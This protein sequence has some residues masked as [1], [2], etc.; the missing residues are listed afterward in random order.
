MTIHIYKRCST[1]Q[2]A[3]SEL[4]IQAQSD[5]CLEYAKQY[6]G[7]DIREYADCGYS[8]SLD[9]LKRPQLNMLM[10][11]L[12]KGDILLAYDSSRIA[13]DTLIW[14]NIEMTC[15]RIGAKIVL[16]TGCN[17]ESLETELIRR[18][19]AQVNEYSLNKMKERTVVALA[20]KKKQGYKLGNA[21]YGYRHS[22]DRKSYIVHEEEQKVISLVY[23]MRNN[24]TSW[25]N[26]VKHLNNN[27]IATRR[28]KEWNRRC[29]NTTLGNA[30]NKAIQRYKEEM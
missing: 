5:K 28:G 19:M 7:H 14:I 29:A 12:Q 9:V 27:N 16:A 17:G 3:K 13:R 24:K 10:G 26:I 30:I 4:G 1:Q 6:N 15:K 11:S 21:P 25:T 2:Q 23:N 22:D 8:G 18:I 20:E